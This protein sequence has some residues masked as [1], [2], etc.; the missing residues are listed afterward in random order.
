MI[1]HIRYRNFIAELQASAESHDGIRV[2]EDCKLIEACDAWVSLVPG[3]D[4]GIA[5]ITAPRGAT[6]TTAIAVK[7]DPTTTREALAAALSNERMMTLA[8]SLLSEGNRDVLAAAEFAEGLGKLETNPFPDDDNL[9]PVSKP[10]SLDVE[11]WKRIPRAQ[12]SDYIKKMAR[13]IRRGVHPD[14]TVAELLAAT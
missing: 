1:K 7:L 11:L 8:R 9:P 13:G 4:G 14:E 5:A 2:V 6:P 10:P 3:R 12:R